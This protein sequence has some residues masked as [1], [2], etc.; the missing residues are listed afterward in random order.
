M[1]IEVI[2]KGTKYWGESC[3]DGG[4]D[5]IT[6][7]SNENLNEEIVKE[8][9]ESGHMNDIEGYRSAIPG[10]QFVNSAWIRIYGKKAIIT[11]RFGWDV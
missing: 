4:I 3:F 6:L 5:Y 2:K 8:F 11:Q 1:S 7:K 10:G 9:L